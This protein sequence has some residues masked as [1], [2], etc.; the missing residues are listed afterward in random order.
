MV[1]PGAAWFAGGPVR[2]EDRLSAD[3][4]P[5]PGL[6]LIRQAEID[7]LIPGACDQL[8]EIIVFLL[9]GN[10]SGITALLPAE[11]HH[12]IPSKIV[13]RIQ[14]VSVIR[15]GTCRH[16]HKAGFIHRLGVFRCDTRRNLLHCR[17]HPCFLPSLRLGIHS[18]DFFRLL[19]RSAQRQHGNQHH[20]R[21]QQTRQSSKH[22][23]SSCSFSSLEPCL[24]Y[25]LYS[26]R[27]DTSIFY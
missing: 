21:Q 26:K 8:I 13:G 5:D 20:K 7:A 27:S 14:I 22:L 2:I 3:P 19:R 11:I 25:L 24:M 1:F 4:L 18:N 17:F 6:C 23:H 10:G 12:L 16:R 15:K 9:G